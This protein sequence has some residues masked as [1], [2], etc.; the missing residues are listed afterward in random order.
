MTSTAAFDRQLPLLIRNVEVALRTGYSVKRAFEI[1]AQDMPAP[2]STEAQ[3]VVA[4]WDSGQDYAQIFADWLRR[5]PSHD[6]DL[7]LAAMRVQI[8]V[9]GNLADTLQ[10]L[11]QIM[12]QR[13]LKARG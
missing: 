7:L 8:E 1:V 12:A 4:Q 3:W 5:T 6:L 9:Q 10:L 11:A 13:T 2:A